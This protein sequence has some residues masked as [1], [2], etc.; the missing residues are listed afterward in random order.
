MS[1]TPTCSATVIETATMGE[2]GARV[3]HLD[4]W[5]TIPPAA[6]MA[7]RTPPVVGLADW[8][9]GREALADAACGAL[10]DYVTGGGTL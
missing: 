2:D 1:S 8:T 5:L 10:E 7:S 3:V 9:A 4:V 6:T